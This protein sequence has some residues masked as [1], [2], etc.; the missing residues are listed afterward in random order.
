[1]TK[2]ARMLKKAKAFLKTPAGHLVK[3]FAAAFAVTALSNAHHLLDAHGL[4]A[5]KSAGEALLIVSAKA[6]LDAIHVNY[7]ALFRLAARKRG[8]GG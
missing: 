2:G 1:M 7:A 4:D 8:T 6:G 3:V 5:L